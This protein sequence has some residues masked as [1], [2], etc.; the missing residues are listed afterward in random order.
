MYMF[1]E[2]YPYF[3]FNQEMRRLY[4]NGAIGEV[5][6]AEGE[7]NHPAPLEVKLKGG[8]GLRH[9]GNL[10]PSTYFN[11]HA[12]APLM[13]ITDTMPVRVNGLS[14]RDP[15]QERLSI[16]T[17]D[18]GFA[19]LCRMDNGSVF[20]LFGKNIGGYSVY[21]RLHGTRGLMENVRNSPDRSLHI[22]IDKWNLQPG[23]PEDQV[24]SPEFPS[25][26]E[27]AKVRGHGGGDFWTLYHFAEA[28]RTGEQPYLNVI[29]AVAM[30]A[31][32]ILAWKSALEDGAPYEVPD[33]T[34]EE[35]RKQYE[36]DDWSPWPED[37]KP[38]QPFASIRGEVIPSEEAVAHARKFWAN[39][40]IKAD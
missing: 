23:E 35:V 5:C 6:Y 20:R 8:P 18:P 33:F 30:S 14:I 7:Y 37:R 10:I 4:R 29:R 3:N 25:H 13:Y 28:I 24:Y 16:R 40:G 2:N 34:K 39:N 36:N 22:A 32:G 17:G 12:L 15:E 11:T 27:E 19:I 1:A 31:V 21:F 9:W 38:G 26:A